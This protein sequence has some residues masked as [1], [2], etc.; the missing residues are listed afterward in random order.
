MANCN[1]TLSN[2]ATS[3]DGSKGGL[4]TVVYIIH[5]DDVDFANITYVEQTAPYATIDSL[6]TLGTPAAKFAKF[7]FPRNS[8]SYTS[9]AQYD[10]TTNSYSYC[11][12]EL[13]MNFRRMDASKRLAINALLQS[14]CF[15]V[16][17]DA[18]GS[19]YVMGMEEPVESSAMT[20]TT[21]QARTDAN[22]TAITLLDTTSL[23]PLMMTAEC[24]EDDV[25]GN[26]L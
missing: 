16:V 10:G 5:R 19:I 1:T 18:N 7:E 15:A 4:A 20:F 23:L 21:G 24:Y 8:A 13:V 12:N 25:E 3:C 11:Q 22:N 14:D 9:T 2:I 26:S 6:P 17:K